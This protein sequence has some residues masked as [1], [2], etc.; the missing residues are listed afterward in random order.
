VA[1]PGALPLGLRHGCE[2][3]GAAVPGSDA[4][5]A[6]RRLIIAI[7]CFCVGGPLLTVTSIWLLLQPWPTGKGRLLA[8]ALLGPVLLAYGM[9][10]LVHRLRHGPQEPGRRLRSPQE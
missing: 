2:R 3:Y 7:V 5:R 8:G 10:E 9:G 1:I 4:K 6:D